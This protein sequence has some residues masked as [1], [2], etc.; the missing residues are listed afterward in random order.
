M[1]K[2]ITAKGIIASGSNSGTLVSEDVTLV[3]GRSA[4]IATIS[5]GGAPNDVHWGE[6][7]SGDKQLATLIGS[8]TNSTSG[9]TLSLWQIKYVLRGLTQSMHANWSETNSERLIGVVQVEEGTVEDIAFITNTQDATGAPNTGTA[10]TSLTADTIQIGFLGSNGRQSDTPGTIGDGHTS[11]EEGGTNPV[12][13]R[14]HITSEILTATGNVRSSKTGAT[15]RDWCN[16]VIVLKKR[17]TFTVAVVEQRDR[18]RN[19]KPNYVWFLIEDESGAGFEEPMSPELFDSLSDAQVTDWIRELC[20][21]WTA[22]ILDDD[23]LA[24]GDSTRD[25]RMATFVDDTVVI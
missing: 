20:V 19:H 4:I 12:G 13:T 21:I 7:T 24:S 5:D 16:A 1:A 11:V 18:N 3:A 9:L 23:Y 15:S 14:L 8:V 10:G 2:G 22:N 6:D 25:T 17:Q